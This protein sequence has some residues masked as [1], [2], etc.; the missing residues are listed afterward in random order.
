MA[1][2]KPITTQDELDAVLKDRIAREAAKFSDYDALKAAKKELDELK[3][4]KLDEKLSALQAEYDKAKSILADHEKVVTELTTRAT[5]AEH[6]LKQREIAQANGIPYELADRIGG[7][8]EEEMKKDAET[9]AKFVKGGAGSVL[10]L[11]N[12]EGSSASKDPKAAAY[13]SFAKSIIKEN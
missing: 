2:F 8:T 3:G 12:P 9:L 7:A 13:L 10:P 1:E 5:T 6:S 11:G 4:K